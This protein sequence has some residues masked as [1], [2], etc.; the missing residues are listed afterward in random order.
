MRS[1]KGLYQ[2][3]GHA[4]GIILGPITGK[5]LLRQMDPFPVGGH[6]YIIFIVLCVGG[7]KALTVLYFSYS[8]ARFQYRTAVLY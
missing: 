1:K 8:T 3:I 7:S 5:K 2:S 6:I 4:F